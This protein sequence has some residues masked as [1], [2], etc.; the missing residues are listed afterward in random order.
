MVGQ[1]TPAVSAA[2][3]GA[4]SRLAAAPRQ[5]RDRGVAWVRDAG[6]YFFASERGE[7]LT[8]RPAD[9]VWLV[10]ASALVVVSARA[11]QEPSSFL[12]NLSKAFSSLPSGVNSLLAAT[13][14]VA[15]LYALALLL[16]AL[17][18][19]RLGLF[20]DLVLATAVAV[21]VAA[22][23]GRLVT[24]DWP[25]FGSIGSILGEPDPSY[26]VVRLSALSA[27]LLTAAP[28]LSRPYRRF[29]YLLVLV[30]SFAALALELGDGAGV[31]A[32][33]GLGWGAAALVHLVF[34]SPAGAPPTIRV[35]R[36]LR[37]LGVDAVELERL[38]ERTRG[39]ALHR[40]RTGDGRGLLV[41][42]YGRDSIS[43][44]SATRLW[45][46]L[47]RRGTSLDP[48]ASRRELVEHEALTMLLAQRA[49][50]R[51]PDLVAVGVAR[52]RDALIAFEWA[53][54]ALGEAA[55]ADLTDAHLA[56]AWSSLDGEHGALSTRSR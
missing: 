6:S 21:L 28:H 1:D 19:R 22:L 29:G 52:P 53:G 40:A 11:N 51:V 12:D 37:Q 25:E 38:P 42:V 23:L 35:E 47:S 7:P 16:A 9:L 55:E 31:I 26:P 36:A 20:R 46:Y 10:V 41:K 34:G 43:A 27:V 33:L 2:V 54:E 30:C 13:F 4:S 18:R 24:G 45:R 17:L 44:R 5:I 49:G 8:R 3:G 48:T 32:A 14:V 50:V 56:S 15:S 39:V